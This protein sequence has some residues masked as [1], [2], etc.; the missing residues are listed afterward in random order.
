MPKAKRKC[1][2][3][4][5]ACKQSSKLKKLVFARSGATHRTGGEKN[6]DVGDKLIT[7]ESICGHFWFGG[8]AWGPCK[9]SICSK[10]V[11]VMMLEK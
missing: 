1:Q 5:K 10:N 4:E 7:R 9:R 2:V 8:L 3:S 6:K 11:E